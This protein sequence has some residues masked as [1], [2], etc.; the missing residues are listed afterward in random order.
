[1]TP[2]QADRILAVIATTWPNPTMD[3]AQVLLWHRDLAFLDADRATK[4]IEALRL[5]CRWRPSLSQVVEQ[6]RALSRAAELCTPAPAPPATPAVDPRS[7]IAEI[8]R[9]LAAK[10]E[11]R[12]ANPTPVAT[13]EELR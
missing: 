4:A 6:Y 2:E 9:M 13:T 11:R 8:R 12:P 5:E 1:M 3:Q 7:H 10:R